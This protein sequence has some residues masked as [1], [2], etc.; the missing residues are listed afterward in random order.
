MNDIPKSQLSTSSPKRPA[1]VQ[2]LRPPGGKGH[3]RS[4]PLVTL[5]F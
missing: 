2:L 5:I 3:D 4:I 1:A